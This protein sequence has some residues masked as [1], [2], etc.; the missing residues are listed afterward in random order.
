MLAIVLES[1]QEFLVV[2]MCRDNVGHSKEFDLILLDH[3]QDVTESH[4]IGAMSVAA[5]R[6]LHH[7]TR[8]KLL[9]IGLQEVQRCLVRIKVI[10]TAEHKLAQLLPEWATFLFTALTTSS[11]LLETMWRVIFRACQIR[12]FIIV[13]S[14]IYFS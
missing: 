13:C 12:N 14:H 6:C 2:L 11:A 4:V 10:A 8:D 1:I 9:C 7:K 5:S 3:M